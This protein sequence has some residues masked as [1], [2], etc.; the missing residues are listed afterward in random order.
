M[1][2]RMVRRQSRQSGATWVAALWVMLG[3]ALAG[4]PPQA[5]AAAP[6]APSADAMRT[7]RQALNGHDAQGQPFAVVDKQQARLHVF[8]ADGRL[9]G[10]TPALLGLAKGDYSAPGVGE[11]VL[12][13]IPLAERT[14]PAGRFASQPGT[15]LKGESIVWIDYQAALAIHRLRPSPP[16][17]RRAQ[18]LASATA[19]DNRIS[20][21][22]VV[23]SGEFFDR[24]VWP[25]MGQGK[26]VVYVLPE[27]GLAP[28]L[29]RA[30]GTPVRE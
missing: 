2:F 12:T 10:S 3:L 6:S 20:L 27:A 16:A 1:K 26:A 25:V 9:A 17:E 13:G 30:P 24:V 21:G 7:V 22:C 19:D 11:R 29:A 8:H 14:T 5:G 4:A 18:R 28:V 23:V 15:N